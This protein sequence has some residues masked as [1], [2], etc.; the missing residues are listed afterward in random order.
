MY[1]VFLSYSMNPMQMVVVWRLQTLAAASGIH[2]DVPAP[3]MRSDWDTVAERIR[4]SD[5]VMALLTGPVMEPFVKREIEYAL[6]L[7]KRVIPIIESG[8]INPALRQIL[9]NSG[10][11]IFELD[12]ANPGAMEQELATFLQA[13]KISK[14]AKNVF[15]ALA[16][17]FVGLLLLQE[18]SKQ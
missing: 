5:S 8:S 16:G 18:F 6:G 15:L 13:E 4:N 7:G 3:D 14:T 17:T 10:N 1:K 9:Q 12:P 11:R 2:L